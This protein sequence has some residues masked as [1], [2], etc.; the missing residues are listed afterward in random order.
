MVNPLEKIRGLTEF[1]RILIVIL[2][3]GSSVWHSTPSSSGSYRIR[4][5]RESTLCVAANL[6]VVKHSAGMTR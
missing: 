2:S 5:F 1:E 3:D 6:D 4:M